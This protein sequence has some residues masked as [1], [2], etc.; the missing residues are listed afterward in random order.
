MLEKDM[1]DQD[2][3]DIFPSYT[4]SQLEKLKSKLI[5][6]SNTVPTSEAFAA[7]EQKIE[8]MLEKNV[9]DEDIL[10][11]FP[12]YSKSKL[13]ELKKKLNSPS[14]AV[15]TPE[16]K[17]LSETNGMS[18]Y[19]L[20]S[21][22]AFRSRDQVKTFVVLGETGSGKSTLIDSM[23]NYVMKVGLN[24]PFR[25]KI[26]DETHIQPQKRASSSQTEKVAVYNI[27]GPSAKVSI[28]DTPGFGDTQ[29]I[30]RD[31]SITKQIGN[32]FKNDIEKLDYILFVVKASDTRLTDRAK[33][34][35]FKMQ[36]IFGRDMEPY[37]LIM[38]TFSDGGLCN[39]EKALNDAKVPFRQIFK[40]NNSAVFSPIFEVEN[41]LELQLTRSFWNLGITSFDH[42][43]QF[44]KASRPI[45]SL[46]DKGG[47]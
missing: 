45:R 33:W 9:D 42:F 39:C 20:P 46:A 35:Y 25:Y 29:G 43:F 19:R 44:V 17:F 3:L 36:E 38:A 16:A 10:T 24:D 34:V 21:K 7:L 32:Y 6:S 41:Q 8:K 31:L 13:D 15:P 12:S 47:Y 2:I 4:I 11:S 22:K 28:I 23:A 18:F 5:C 37:I 1:D 26:V 27:Q 14:N 40:F 30:D